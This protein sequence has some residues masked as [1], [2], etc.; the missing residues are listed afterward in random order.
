[1]WG[2]SSIKHLHLVLT[3]KAP[4]NRGR[5]GIYALKCRDL[6]VEDTVALRKS[7]E[8][9]DKQDVNSR[10]SFQ[11]T[12]HGAE[13]QGAGRVDSSGKQEKAVRNLE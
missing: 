5:N 7:R 13:T 2:V 4:A 10:P 8:L 12:G 6:S 11:A 9:R 1:M 3:L